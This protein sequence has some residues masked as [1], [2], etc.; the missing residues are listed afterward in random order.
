MN[1]IKDSSEQR[2]TFKEIEER[3]YGMYVAEGCPA[4]RSEAHW[5]LAEEQLRAELRRA[6]TQPSGPQP[7]RTGRRRK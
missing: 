6:E 5:R 7:A 4:S 2:P 3:A 1:A